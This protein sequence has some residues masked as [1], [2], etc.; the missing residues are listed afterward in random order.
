MALLT[1]TPARLITPMPVMMMPKGMWW[2][3]SPRNT[4][5]SDSITV[6]MMISGT[7]ERVELRHQDQ[8]DQQQR[9]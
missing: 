5:I 6:V 2:T 8:R 1:T 9:R 3:S 7:D 4:P